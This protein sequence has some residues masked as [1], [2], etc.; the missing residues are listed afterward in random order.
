MS[1]GVD[2]GQ[3]VP[4]DDDIHVVFDGGV[5]GGIGRFLDLSRA[6]EVPALACVHG[7]AEEVCAVSGRVGDGLFRGVLGEPLDAVAA[8]A[9]QLH[10][11]AVLVAELRPLHVEFSVLRHAAARFDRGRGRGRDCGCIGQSRCFLAG[12]DL[13]AA[14]DGAGLGPGQAAFGVKTALVVS[15]HHAAAVGRQDLV[16]VPPVQRGK[17][18]H[19]CRLRDIVAGLVGQQGAHEDIH[20]QL[21]GEGKV[22]FFPCG[23]QLVPVIPPRLQRRLHGPGGPVGG[24]RGRWF[25]PAAPP[26]DGDELRRGDGAPGAESAVGIAADQPLGGHIP[27]V[28]GKPV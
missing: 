19:F 2:V 25:Q 15:C 9:V 21:A 16:V 27:H 20:R 22:I 26:H 23:G 3:D 8:H 12:E 10:R 28:G 4:V 1:E 13:G 5:H 14:D 24:G 18:R 7:D 6:G 17:V 11:C